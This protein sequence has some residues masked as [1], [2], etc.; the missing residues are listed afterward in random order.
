M[1]KVSLGNLTSGAVL[2]TGHRGIL[3]R[4]VYSALTNIFPGRSILLFEGDI[5]SNADVDDFLSRSGRVSQLINCAAIVPVKEAE[6]NPLNTYKV[7]CFGPGLLMTKL[8]Q[9]NPNAH[10]IQISSSH[11]Y[12]ASDKPTLNE[13]DPTG[14]TGT[15]G[16]SKLAGEMLCQDLAAASDT[17]LCIARV[18]S[19]FS[20]EQEGDYLYPAIRRKLENIEADAP[21]PLR[22]WNNIRD[23][24]SAEDHAK[25]IS[26]LAGKQFEGTVNLGSGVATSV[27]QFASK[28]AGSEL[29]F[30]EGDFDP[31]PSVMVA[32]ITRLKN[33]GWLE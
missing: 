25:R 28:I 24:S 31:Y 15:Y 3:G 29:N 21:F 26:H 12:A 22:G 7:N 16:K 10:F 14:P 1:T 5:T 18:F 20:A 2:L 6:A 17:R 4:A 8:T 9:S 33:S 13:D 11:V 32:D 23:F 19:L 30:S 27:G